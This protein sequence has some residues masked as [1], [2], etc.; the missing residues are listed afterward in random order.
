[1]QTEAK[2]QTSTKPAD[3]LEAIPPCP[4][5]GCEMSVALDDPPSTCC[6]RYLRNWFACAAA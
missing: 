2:P 6:R 3:Q 5:C 4:V 1:M